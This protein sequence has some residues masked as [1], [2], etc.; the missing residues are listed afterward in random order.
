MK[1]EISYGSYGLTPAQRKYCIT[2]KDLL[3]IVRFTRQ[4]RHYLLGR[5]LVVR[6]DHNSMTWLLRFKN[7]QDM[8]V[9]WIEELSQFDMKIQH[10]PGKLQSNADGLSR[11]PDREQFCESYNTGTI[12]EDLPCKGCNFC[13]RAKNQ[14]SRYEE[15]IEYVT[16]LSLYRITDEPG[17]WI[18]GCRRHEK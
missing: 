18:P 5:P 11:I 6:T 10:R 9:R 16:P 8:L 4:Y 3:A 7:I 17:H 1:R 13:K 15:D 2:R 14:R 12:L